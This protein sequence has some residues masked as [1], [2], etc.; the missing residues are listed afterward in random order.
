MRF[1]HIK[2]IF[3][4]GGLSRWTILLV[5]SGLVSAILLLTGV[6]RGDIIHPAYLWIQEVEP[7]QFDILWK[8]PLRY[9]MRLPIQPVFPGHCRVVSE[10]KMEQ[11]P[12]ALVDRWRMECGPGGL[13]GETIEI[14]GLQLTVMDVFV[15]VQLLD[16]RVYEDQLRP[17]L[18]RYTIA[19]RKSFDHI[20]V[21]HL[22]FGLRHAVRQVPVMLAVFALVLLTGAKRRLFG[23]LGAFAV[24]YAA[25]FIANAF[26]AI[27]A[28]SEWGIAACGIAGF[29]LVMISLIPSKNVRY[30]SVGSLV[31]LWLG[32]LLGSALG[33]DWSRSGLAYGDIPLAGAALFGGVWLGL[34]LMA[35]APILIKLLHHDFNGDRLP[36]LAALPAYVLGSTAVYFIIQSGISLA[37]AG[38]VQPYARP[39]SLVVAMAMGILIGRSADREATVTALVLLVAAAFGV[40]SGANAMELPFGSAAIPLS[41]AIMGMVLLLL[42]R[43]SLAARLGIACFSG[44]FHGWINGKWLTEH[45]SASLPSAVGGMVLLAGLILGG[46]LLRKTVKPARGAALDAV[47]G[48]ALISGAFIMRFS[49]YRVSAFREISVGGAAVMRIP[50]LSVILVTM[51]ILITVIAVRKGSSALRSPG[52]AVPWTLILILGLLAVPYGTLAVGGGPAAAADMSDQEAK[53]L[54]AGLLANTYRAVNLKGEEE[55][56]DRLSMSVD[57][58]LVE[59]LYLESRKRSVIPSQADAEAKL[60]DVEVREILERGPAGDGIGYSFTTHWQVAGTIRHWAHKHNRL[61][62]YSGVLTLRAVDD[63][64]KLYELEL[65][66]EARI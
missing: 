29:A 59:K 4:S 64:W 8:T 27:G 34:S 15:R 62:R 13:D 24:G 7:G 49:G 57:G 52:T 56:Y 55:I 65:L 66:D 44:L 16:G 6:A 17:A 5:L 12:G 30:S 20:A 21:T 46:A 48:I 37:S 28:A 22:G 53:E 40:Y 26:G 14:R 32:I 39:E 31:F 41:L 19:S 50:V 54:I 58:E 2:Y 1:T 63:V 3:Y 61:N 45:V 51:A 25:G 10:P 23:L 43:S 60:I 36:P 18:P 42:T 33:G 47:A 9:G 35:A 11:L 38:P